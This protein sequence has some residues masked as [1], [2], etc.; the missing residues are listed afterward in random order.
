MSNND[1]SSHP[2]TLPAIMAYFQESMA[3][4]QTAIADLQAQ[5]KTTISLRMTSLP[6]SS[7]RPPLRGPGPDRIQPSP[8]ILVRFAHVA[9]D[10]ATKRIVVSRIP[11]IR[12]T[13][14]AL[15]LRTHRLSVLVPTDVQRCFMLLTP[16]ARLSRRLP[17]RR[18]I[19]S[20]CS[21]VGF[22]GYRDSPN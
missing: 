10:K 17:F 7:K 11:R 5:I 2:V 16:T 6:A 19:P 1:E 8:S 13:V 18:T 4:Q 3:Q 22:T 21:T 12:T 15:P 14:L 9:V 20:L